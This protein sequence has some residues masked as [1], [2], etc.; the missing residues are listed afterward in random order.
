MP[1]KFRLIHI[2]RDALN[3]SLRDEFRVALQVYLRGKGY[4]SKVY[5]CCIVSL[6]PNPHPT[7]LVQMFLSHRPAVV[8]AVAGGCVCPGG[9]AVHWTGVHSDA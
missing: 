4:A 8:V 9:A 3:K 2:L 6:P 7:G 5:E 1:V